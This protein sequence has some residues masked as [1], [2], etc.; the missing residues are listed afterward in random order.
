MRRDSVTT[1]IQRAYGK[2]YNLDTYQGIAARPRYYLSRLRPVMGLI[3]QRRLQILVVLLLALV[4]GGSI[5]YFNLLVKTEQDV[6]SA[7]GKVAA[8]EQR[9]ND[10]SIN[11]SKAV[12]DYSKH[13][14]SVF[15]AV[16]ALRSFLSEKGVKGAELEEVMKKLE[17]SKMPGAEK[18]SEGISGA[19]PLS[20][21]N[22][23]LA[24]AEQYPD[25]KLSANFD[26]LMTALID[27]EKDL[28]SERIKFNDAVNTYTTNTA[29]FPINVYA[30]I[31]GF[32]VRPYFEATEDAKSFKPIDY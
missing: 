12:Y 24:I 28:A 22:G 31:F 11:L 15:T 8:L 26:N 19:G 27:V 1:L 32:Q 16:V 6:L 4:T 2:R 5:Y 25:L 13:E 9:R 29:K 23:L 10:I 20:A 3:Q 18:A 7:R 30:W 17:L 21:L 14:R